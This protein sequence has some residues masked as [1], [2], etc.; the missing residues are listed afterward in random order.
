MKYLS[1]NGLEKIWNESDDRIIL[2]FD[3]EPDFDDG[4]DQDIRDDDTAY[5]EQIRNH[6][7]VVG[8][9]I[10]KKIQCLAPRIC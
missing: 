8:N 7:V 1:D 4:D 3:L 9:L 2:N 10:W 5:V 6:T